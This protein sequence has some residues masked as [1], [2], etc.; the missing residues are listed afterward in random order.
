[1]ADTA[2]ALNA[3]IGRT[4]PRHPAQS[5]STGAKLH[6][7]RS[8]THELLERTPNVLVL[9]LVLLVALWPHWWWMARRLTDGSDEPWGIVALITAIT[10]VAREWRALSVPSSSVLHATAALAI[11]A[12]ISRLWVPPLGA[13][14][15]A[16]TALATFLAGARRARPATALASLLL[17]ALPVIAT[18]Q[19]YFGYP[20]RLATATLAAPILRGLGFAVEATGAAL[21][22]Q[23]QLVLI[24]PPCAGIGMLWVGAFTASLLSYVANASAGRTI[25]N[26]AVAA[27]SVFVANV[28]R[29]VA[30]F[31]PEALD[32]GW[33]EWMHAFIGLIAFSLALLPIVLFAQSSA[34]HTR[35]DLLDWPPRY[36]RRVT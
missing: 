19:F 4:A 16:M 29:N 30:L 32:L 22:W 14:V 25:L 12:A 21:A 9:L 3:R 18:L 13:A 17:L 35:K 15:I 23:G 28:A 34:R 11:G 26:G 36:H 27:A 2:I 6:T 24:D 10:L 7:A 5:D 33:P 20:L 8:R 1:V 31:F